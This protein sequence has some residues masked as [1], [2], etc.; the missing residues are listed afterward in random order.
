MYTLKLNDNLKSEL[1][2][3]KRVSTVV[4]ATGRL[5]MFFSFS[6]ISHFLNESE[7]LLGQSMTELEVRFCSLTFDVRV[8]YPVCLAYEKREAA[9]GAQYRGR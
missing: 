6:R 4:G 1:S 5:R 7:T 9:V 8:P 3:I 2:E